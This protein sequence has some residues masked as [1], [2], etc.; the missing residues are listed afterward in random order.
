MVLDTSAIVAI[1]RD[2]PECAE[3][4]HLLATTDDPLISAATLLESSI[5][6]H[7]KVGDDAVADLDHLLQ[8]AGVRCVA[9][10]AAQAV[11]ARTAWARYGKGRSP[12]GLN[13]GDL[14]SY[15]LAATLD[16]ALLYKGDDF[17]KTDIRSAR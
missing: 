15:A 14:F 7:A 9:V 16:R 10:D 6:L 11:A 8:A 1:L 4:V 3:F 13:Y 2:E 12:A 5:V 17:A